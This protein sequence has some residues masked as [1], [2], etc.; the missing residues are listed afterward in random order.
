[1]IKQRLKIWKARW[2]V[3]CVQR[4]VENLSPK[5]LTDLETA[6]LIARSAPQL[7][8][9]LQLIMFLNRIQKEIARRS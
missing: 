9:S 7:R 8:N 3:Y 4:G 5:T 2:A 1:M 6:I